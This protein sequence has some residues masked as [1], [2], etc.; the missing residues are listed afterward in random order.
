MAT[1]ENQT[2]EELASKIVAENVGDSAES[3]PNRELAQSQNMLQSD[4]GASHSG[5]DGGRL[6]SD[7]DRGKSA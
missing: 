4:G 5:V 3:S 7:Y 1:T 2:V 6:E